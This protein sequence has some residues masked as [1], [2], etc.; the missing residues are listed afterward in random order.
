MRKLLMLLPMLVCI[1]VSTQA[2]PGSLDHSFAPGFQ[3]VFANSPAGDPSIVN[4]ITPQPDGKLLIGGTI[5]FTGNSSSSELVRLMPD[6]SVDPD[7]IPAI[8]SGN[9][10]RAIQVQSDG[11]I[12]VGLDNGLLRLNSDGQSDAGFA[13]TA[14]TVGIQCVKI[15]IQADGKIVCLSQ[16]NTQFPTH[17]TRLLP[18]GNPD[19]GFATG[20]IR[21]T[22][23]EYHD[24]ALQSD[25]KI[26]VV[27]LESSAIP[28]IP[29]VIYRLLADGTLDNSFTDPTNS[30]AMG[31][32]FTGVMLQ[33]DGKIIVHYANLIY[34]L[35][36]DGS[37]SNETNF[38]AIRQNAGIWSVN[39]QQDGKLLIGESFFVG[40]QSHQQ[41]MRYFADGTPDPSYYLGSGIVDGAIDYHIFCSAMINGDQLLV[42]GFFANYNGTTVKSLVRID[43]DGQVDHG[44]GF[45]L[46]NNTAISI[47]KI[48]QQS[49]DKI[50]I[51][52]TFD[53]YNGQSRN[54]IL[55]LGLNGNIDENYH[56]FFSE[57]LPVTAMVLQ[58]DD[59][60]ICARVAGSNEFNGT[61]VRINTDG[62]IDPSFN[63]G[64]GVSLTG[65]N[66]NINAI[67]IQADGKILVGGQFDAYNNIQRKCLMRINTDGSLDNSFDPGIGFVSNL[68]PTNAS[69]LTITTDAS[70]KILVGG[71][72]DSYNGQSCH[73][74]VRLNADGSMDNSFNTGTGPG[75]FNFTGNGS[76]ES[77]VV[78]PDG[79]ILAS[80]M[81]TSFNGISRIDVV[82]LND[83]GSVDAG[84]VPGLDGSATDNGVIHIRSLSLQPD[85]KLIAVGLFDYFGGTVNSIVRLNNDGSRD[86]GFQTGTGIDGFG[87]QKQAYTSL[88]QHD[89][90][91]LIGGYISS[92][93]QQPVNSVVRI[94]TNG[95]E[96]NVN[97][98]V[99]ISLTGGFIPVPCIGGSLSFAATPIFG[100]NNPAYLWKLN[101]VSTGVTTSTFS[102]D[103]FTDGDI[104]TCEMTSSHLCAVPLTVT[105]N[106]ITIAVGQPQSWYLDEDQD[107]YY[108]GTPVVSCF[109]PGPGYYNESMGDIIQGGNDCDDQ[110][111][112]IHP[113]AAEIPGNGI[114]ENCNGLID[115][116][117]TPVVGTDCLLYMESVTIGD[118]VNTNNG[119]N[120]SYSDFSA[121]HI[122]YAQSN[123]VI[124]F[125]I[126]SPDGSMNQQVNLYVDYNRNGSFDDAGELVLS[127]GSLLAGI[128]LTGN[129]NLPSGLPNGTYRLRIVSD[130]DQFTSSTACFTNWGEVEDYTL[131]VRDVLPDC[132][133]T[134]DA[135]CA[136]AVMSEVIIREYVN[137]N[138]LNPQITNFTTC[139][140]YTDYSADQY[141][142]TQAG[143]TL[144]M[145]I[146]TNIPGVQ[147]VN[148]YIDYNQNGFY[149]DPGEEII[150]DASMESI[151]PAFFNFT[152]PG[153]LLD[154]NY[155]IR[156]VA[157]AVNTVAGA[158][159]L[160][161]GEVEDYQLRI[162]VCTAYAANLS[163]FSGSSTQICTGQTT[164]LS[165][166]VPQATTDLYL[167]TVSDGTNSFSGAAGAVTG[168][169][170]S[171]PQSVNPSATTS[172]YLITVTD[173]HNCPATLS[174]SVT[175]E[176]GNL[177]ITPAANITQPTCAVSTGTISITPV[178]GTGYNYSVGGS[179]Q[180]NPI[181]SNLP[182]GT[183]VLSIQSG[184]GCISSQTTSVQINPQ[185]LPPAT[186][187]SVSGPVNVCP[188]VGTATQIGYKVSTD[189]NASGYQWTVPPTVTIVNGQGT[190]SI[191]VLINAGFSSNANKLIKVKALSTC[192]NSAEKLLYLVAQLPSTPSQIVASST[193]ICASIGTNISITYKIAKVNGAASYLWTAQN[194][195]TIISHP[196]GAGVNDTL[197]TV[198]FLAG[199]T[200]SNI[201]VQALNDCGSS[202]VRSLA[203]TRNEPSLPGLISGPTN[204]CPYISP[205]GI[206]ATYSV[207]PMAGITQYNWSVPAGVIGLTGQGTAVISFIYPA[208]YT[209]GTISV[210]ATNGCGTGAT[211][212]LVVTTLNPATPGIIDVIN[213]ITCPDRQ[214]SYTIASMPA[215][216]T[217]VVWTVVNGAIISGQGT[218]SITVA[219]GSGAINGS[220]SVQAFNNC[221]ASAVRTIPVRLPVCPPPGLIAA[222]SFNG[223]YT[224]LV[225]DD[226]GFSVNVYPNPS[227][228]YFSLE[229]PVDLTGKTKLRL[230]DVQGKPLMTLTSS[231][232]GLIN[233]GNEL[234]AGVYILEITHGDRRIIR[235]LIKL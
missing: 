106:S 168:Q 138:Y 201:T 117:C 52:G 164:T 20:G 136:D 134:I 119:C 79:K 99:N 151:A 181:F 123:G 180:S 206:A 90:K 163:L 171:V 59:K 120:H 227:N 183:Y 156:I 23:G 219:Y 145:Q 47:R 128:P 220:V 133:P 75:L 40:Q 24:I 39:Q 37:L 108:T 165:V 4:V 66:G 225:A 222:K 115:E 105:S 200:N 112:Q 2:Q 74:I 192:G 83:D 88:L 104:L 142:L 217:S 182:P 129:I 153:N 193:N 38:N 34:Q 60:L 124:P 97:P 35:N 11:K 224:N 178:S 186:P 175:I 32:M 36:A 78:Q 77:I 176:V 150:T 205:N 3:S 114:D 209:G 8:P 76:I 29:R 111:S 31:S 45:S 157:H 216:A 91:L 140:G 162:G 9:N 41:V 43:N 98:A 127:G 213:T 155:R 187:G 69:V 211:R 94:I 233:F 48:V 103:T 17:L 132:M 12:L 89:G 146:G 27:G 113:N 215:N 166:N 68:G 86:L 62:N 212:T 170:L 148:V 189:P 226:A 50:I 137:G 143:A 13:Y 196:N 65:H 188:Y 160:A 144:S 223:S 26:V 28:A 116:P 19:P 16:L 141:I 85:G 179:Y 51:G 122:V 154:G 95:C 92:Y 231:T 58:A 139:S 46:S 49:D 107:G 131:S 135:P 53:G 44:T 228:H 159:Q 126:S 234:P 197:V 221:K 87:V 110:Q 194:G 152:L 73:G 25:G 161:A 177:N 10:V 121:N 232:N 30:N 169:D 199:F 203:I 57:N 147:L 207:I 61:M 70:G 14:A 71:I 130:N 118:M 93:N 198:T 195:T 72:F 202:S 21:L 102:G 208:G 174:G 173:R 81:F 167:Y 63:T 54:S 7:F 190:D 109:Y 210:S 191:T 64:V 184:S 6:G 101:G 42:G 214:Y 1:A 80:G 18:D 218:T 230:F 125:S 229:L 33:S 185:P 22:D 82:R 96:Q 172:Y 56:P 100:G 149:D 55:R 84:F 15:L 5:F 204:A 67:H 158:C 235:R